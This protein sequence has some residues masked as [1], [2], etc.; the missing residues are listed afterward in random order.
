MASGESAVEADGSGSLGQ[1][2][3]RQCDKQLGAE[4]GAA[5]PARRIG[6]VGARS[7]ERRTG[8]SWMRAAERAASATLSICSSLPLPFSALP[9]DSFFSRASRA[10]EGLFTGLGRIHKAD[11]YQPTYP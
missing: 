6:E 4:S 1:A 10:E 9:V 11:T 8:M 2:N 5:V 3:R 7:R